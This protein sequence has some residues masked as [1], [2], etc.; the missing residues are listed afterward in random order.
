MI[1]VIR[2]TGSYA[3]Q[4]RVSNN[5]LAKFVET[6]DQ[7]I[8]ER[9]GISY[10]HIAEEETTTSMAVEAAK[11]ALKKSGLLSVEVDMIIVATVSSE[12]IVP[13][14][15]CVVQSEI[16]ATN[17]I[18]FDLNAACSGFIFGY[19]TAQAY[20]SLGVAK[21]VLVIGVESLSK[22]VNW[23]ERDTCVLFGDGA[24]AVLLQAE[25]G[26]YCKP[27]M[28]SNGSL[29]KALTCN[30]LYPDG[31]KNDTHYLQMDGHEVFKFATKQVP[32]VIEELLESLNIAK[33]E[34]DCFVVHQAN[35]R[36]VE[37]LARRLECDIQKFPMNIGEYGNTSSAS[38]PILLDELY[39]EGELK[40]GMK[41]VVSGF[42]A[43]LTW[44]AAYME[45]AEEK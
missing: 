45:I 1:G 22:I 38:I 9:T 21:N 10:R 33:D 44:G 27:V 14:T 13:S 19:N 17:A 2:G 15:A 4:K 20:I 32:N 12:V 40:P 37:V 35:Q 3:P 11:R 31:T 29:G 18:A 42:G 26:E 5:D 8:Y 6:S 7:W 23:K 28:H 36:I 24:G 30:N 43:G 39:R 16:G 25:E 34:I 41:V